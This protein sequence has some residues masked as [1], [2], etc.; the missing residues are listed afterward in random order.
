MAAFRGLWIGLAALTALAVAPALAAPPTDPFDERHQVYDIGFTDSFFDCGYEIV[1]SNTGWVKETLTFDDDGNLV[2]VLAR[3]HYHGSF[4]NPATGESYSYI[5][6]RVEKVTDIVF[7]PDGSPS[8]F[9]VTINGMIGRLV[10]PGGGL[11]TADTGRLAIQVNFDANGNF[12]S[13]EVLFEAG[14]H[15]GDAFF[16][17][18]GL[19]ELL[20]P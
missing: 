19:C 16:G 4:T 17:S 9:T 12:V 10:V 7:N 8:T 15:D 18:G 5:G 11:L 14:I 1:Q 6:E 2:A 13:E 3:V 20:L